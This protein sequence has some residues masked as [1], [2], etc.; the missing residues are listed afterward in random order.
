M[1]THSF[2]GKFQ[3]TD[4][5]NR[6]IF[7]AHTTWS[8]VS[9]ID[10]VAGLNEAIA[11]ADKI[12]GEMIMSE[13]MTPQSQQIMMG[14]AMAPQDSL[15]TSVLTPAQTDSLDVMLRNYMG[16]MASAKAVCPTQTGHALHSYSPDSES[17]C[18]S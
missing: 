9:V 12:Y 8:P 2:Y 3:A 16:P 4:L 6:H 13:S 10:S 5:K 18:V 11:S 15:L 14:Y 1:A 17:D 7:S